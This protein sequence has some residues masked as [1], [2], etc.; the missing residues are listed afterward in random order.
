LKTEERRDFNKGSMQWDAD[1][2]R[3][4]L[5]NGVATAIIREVALSKDMNALD[6]GCGTGLVTLQLQP[7]V[8]T[9]TGADSSQGML[10]V[11]DDKIRTQGL[12]NISTILVDFEKGDRIEGK[13]HLIVCTMTL[14]HVPDTAALFRLWFDM[15]LPGGY[16]CFSDLDTEDGSF[17]SDKTGVFHFGFDRKR[18]R[19][20]LQVAGFSEV[21]DTTATTMPRKV[22]G[23]GI[24]EFPVFLMVAKKMRQ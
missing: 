17:H 15:L 24:C 23:K 21:R 6:F 1:L 16:L 22:E 19:E 20:L 5:A 2:S 8:G 9:I 3:V 4:K 12:A 7:L 13:F 14:H 11:L 18:L 10:A